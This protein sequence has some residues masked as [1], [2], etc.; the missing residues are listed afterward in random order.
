MADIGDDQDI[1]AGLS[2]FSAHAGHL[3]YMVD[4]ARRGSL[5]IIDEPGLGTDPDEGVALAMAVLD[6]LLQQGVFTAVSTHSNRLKAYGLLNK[7]VVNASVEFDEERFCPTFKLTYGSPGISHALEMASSIGISQEILTR[8]RA[9]LDQDEVELNRLIE[10][11]NRLIAE[12]K[13][14]RLETEAAKN[15]YHEALKETQDRL[16]RLESEKKALIEAKRVEA[17]AAI[18]EAR[19]DLK[20]AINLL[21]SKQESV[22]AYVTDRVAEVGD[23]LLNRFKVTSRDGPIVEQEA[24]KEGQVVFH[25]KL[26]QEGTVQKVGPSAG[27]A[28]ILLGKVRMNARIEDLEVVKGGQVS[29]P[30]KSSGAVSWFARGGPPKELDVIGF[31]VDDALHLIDKTMDRAMVDGALTFR[32]IHGFGTGTLREAIRTHLKGV[33]FVKK[34]CSADP[35]SGGDA[36]TV[37]ELS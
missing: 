4:H 19:E 32:I 30:Q 6:F 21:K 31:R 10:K 35:K 18:G 20:K 37:V 22:Q 27:V 13:R 33:P 29:G 24:I 34:V 17:E 1:Q 14:E 16:I 26:K 11:L 9:Y 28:R 15:Q 12:G 2:T 25:K 23:R 7:G 36:I 3:G 8:A 5:A